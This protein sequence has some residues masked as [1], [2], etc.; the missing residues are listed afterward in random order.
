MFIGN[1]NLNECPVF[2][3]IKPTNPIRNT[4][5]LSKLDCLEV[6]FLASAPAQVERKYPIVTFWENLGLF[7]FISNGKG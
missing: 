4:P 1:S 7:I 3:F 2:L 5:T 6:D